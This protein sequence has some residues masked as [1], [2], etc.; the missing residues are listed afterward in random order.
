MNP[1]TSFLHSTACLFT[2]FTNSCVNSVIS[3]DVFSPGITSTN[4][5]NCGGLKKC[6]PI[7][8]SGRDVV[9]AISVIGNVLV[10]DAKITSGPAALSNSA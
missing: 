3:C 8:F 6:M 2:D 7:N 4:F 1:G 9:F 10:F 5:I